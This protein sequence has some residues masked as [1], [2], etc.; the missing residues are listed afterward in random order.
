MLADTGKR[1]ELMALEGGQGRLNTVV[2]AL[3]GESGMDFET[4]GWFRRTS[5]FEPAATEAHEAGSDMTKRSEVSY[6]GCAVEVARQRLESAYGGAAVRA[7]DPRRCI[8][9]V[10]RQSWPKPRACGGVDMA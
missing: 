2:A 5:R 7:D 10:A 8:A 1:A 6:G 4:V 3:R 9:R